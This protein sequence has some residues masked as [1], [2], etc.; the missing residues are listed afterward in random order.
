MYCIF[1]T[2]DAARVFILSPSLFPPLDSDDMYV[3]VMKDEFHNRI[4]PSMNEFLF[5]DFTNYDF[6]P[7]PFPATGSPLLSG[8]DFTGLFANVFFEKV[9]FIGSNGD[10]G[11][12][13]GWTN[14]TP[15]Q[16]NYNN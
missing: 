10:A 15:L 9:A 2:E 7:K 12:L 16:T 4:F 14:F 11:W 8:A 13:N 3:H 1:H 5:T 6:S